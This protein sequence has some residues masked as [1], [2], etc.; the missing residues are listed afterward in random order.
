[1]QQAKGSEDLAGSRTRQGVK[2]AL[3][4]CQQL[5]DTRETGKDTSD[6]ERL[7]SSQHKKKMNHHI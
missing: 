6:K 3:E 7:L 2:T 1:M 4:L 5:R